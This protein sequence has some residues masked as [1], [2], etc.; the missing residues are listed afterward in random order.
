MRSKDDV[1]TQA[2]ENVLGVMAIG[3]PAVGIR[4]VLLCEQDEAGE[5][6]CSWEYSVGCLHV[7]ASMLCRFYQ[8]CSASA[9]LRRSSEFR[10]CCGRIEAPPCRAFLWAE[11]IAPNY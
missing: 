1:R 4:R 11:S 7:M 9:S 5:V 8:K 6:Q 3:S 10:Q 2:C